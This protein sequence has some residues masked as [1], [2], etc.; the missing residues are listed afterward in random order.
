M[1]SMTGLV[2]ITRLAG[3]AEYGVYT[4]AFSIWFALQALSELS[5]DVWLVRRAD[6]GEALAFRT[7]QGMLIILGVAGSALCALAAPLAVVLT[8]LPEIGPVLF[9][10]SPLAFVV[11][12]SQA[13]LSYLERSFHFALI[14]L[15]ELVG[16]TIFAATGITFA[17]AG[18]GARGLALALVAQQLFLAAAWIIVTRSRV[19]PPK[20]NLRYVLEGVRFGVPWTSASVL[21]SVRATT[22]Q[23]VVARFLGAETLGVL[24][25]TYRLLEQA[26]FLRSAALR[27]SVALFG[28]LR[29]DP[30][31]LGSM[32]DRANV[33]LLTSGGIPALLV[34]WLGAWIIPLV[35]GGEWAP[36]S[37]LFVLILPSTLLLGV[38]G[39]YGSVAAALDKP[40]LNLVSG[41]VFAAVYVICLLFLVPPLETA[42]VAIAEASC[43]IS[44]VLYLNGLGQVLHV[45]AFLLQIVCI[46]SV[47][48]SAAAAFFT[49]ILALCGLV[50]LLFPS[51]RNILTAEVR[52]IIRSRASRQLED[53]GPGSS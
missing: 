23:I 8:G 12:V 4:A 50:P 7:G 31:R 16:Q 42:G 11:T 27:L 35:F 51:V 44:L 33:L 18:G 28:R 14:G 3:P 22:L 9:L 25:L 17:A 29:S 19:L 36:V 10:M 26:V 20:L 6:E 32:V 53:P 34:A 45:R 43:L 2:V 40:R 39:L 47:S 1:I 48:V 38:N 13:G 37:L 5:L 46:V 41:A 52:A 15:I 49:P 21:S 30:A 24:N